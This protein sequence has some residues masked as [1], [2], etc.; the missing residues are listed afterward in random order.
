MTPALALLFL[1]AAAAGQPKS[2][3]LLFAGGYTLGQAGQGLDVYELNTESGELTKLGGSVAVTN[4]SFFTLSPDGRF[5]Y[6][7]TESKL[8]GNGHVSAFA[9]DSL[10]GRLTALNKRSSGGENPVYVT[11]DRRFVVNVNYTAG[12]A[13]VFRLNANGSLQD[14]AQLLRFQGSGLNPARQDGPHLHAAV[15]SPDQ[16]YLFITDLGADRIRIF[17]WDTTL[18]S[19]AVS[20]EELSVVT[21][22]GSGPRHLEFHPT[23][24][25]AYCIEELSGTVTAYTYAEGKLEAIQRLP[26]YAQPHQDYESADIHVS[27]D[28][29]FLYASNRRPEHNLSIFSIDQV[30]G[31]LKP[32]GHQSTYG[33]HPRNFAIDPSG[34]FLA[35]A[36]VSTGNIVVFKRNLK[37]GALTRVKQDIKALNPSCLRF[38]TYTT[39]L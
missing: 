17:K 20:H 5:L 12:N 28:G 18:A 9:I 33:E 30:T 21:V 37:T 34:R 19:P 2:R 8:P 36:N 25:L 32:I 6:A 15:F 39:S 3:T 14:P 10:S 16:R 7:C 4:P 23:L 29:L 22:A 38:R 31:K 1:C 13:S 24:P 35:V 11:A 26:S 27:P